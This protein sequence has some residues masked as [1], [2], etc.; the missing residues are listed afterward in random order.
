MSLLNSKPD[1]S[2]SSATRVP[3]APELKAT[4]RQLGWLVV[5]RWTYK[6]LRAMTKYIVPKTDETGV[7]ISEVPDAGRGCFI[8]MPEKRMGS[9]ALILIHGG[10]LVIGTNREVLANACSFARE[11]GIPVISPAYGLGPENPFPAGLNDLHATW[12]WLLSKADKMGI[13]PA[14]IVIGGLSAGGCMAASIVQRLHDEGGVQPAAQLL[15]YPMLDDRTAANRD[16]DKPRHRVWSNRNNHFGWSRYLAQDPGRDVPTYA[17]PARREDYIGLPPAWIGVGAADL[18]LDE[19]RAYA[20][21][22]SDAGVDVT[23]IEAPGAIHGFDIA[24]TPM[25]VEFTGSQIEFVKQFTR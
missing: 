2:I 20:Q 25:G 21:N 14:K 10:G 24:G 5:N 17:V 18:F 3:T 23:Y 11:A 15:I 7:T 1:T 9:G 16:L 22:L 4:D 13:D 19:D 8:V 6:I 12:H